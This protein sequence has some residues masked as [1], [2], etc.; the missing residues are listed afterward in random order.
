MLPSNIPSYLK[1][2]DQWVLWKNVMRHGSLAKVPFQPNGR[3]ARSNEPKTWA[4]FNRCYAAYERG[5]FEGLGFCF[6]E[7]DGLVGID[8]DDCFEPDALNVLKPWA[9]E[10][11][12]RFD[13]T[14]QERTPSG[15]G[16]HIWCLGKAQ[17]SGLGI[18]NKKIEVY[19]YRSPRYFTVTGA[20]LNGYGIEEMQEDLDWLHKQELESPITPVEQLPFVPRTN[21]EREVKQALECVSADDYATWINIGMALKAAGYALSMWDWWSSRSSKYHPAACAAKW[22][23]FKE[24]GKIGL[25]TV[26]YHARLNGFH[27]RSA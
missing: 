27:R 2:L 13:N 24:G 21:D 18:R 8:L 3:K 15:E 17:R 16:L 6:A 19:D 22:K 7:G 20:S 23:T 26:F 5:K 4:S 14:W 9:S 1:S 10:I 12:F 11:V 25:G